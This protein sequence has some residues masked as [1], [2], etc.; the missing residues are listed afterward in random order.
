MIVGEYPMPFPTGLNMGGFY[1]QNDF[2]QF[3]NQFLNGQ[4]DMMNGGACTMM[5]CTAPGMGACNMN[6]N[7]H[8]QKCNDCEP[9]DETIRININYI[10]PLGLIRLAIIV[11]SYFKDIQ[12]HVSYL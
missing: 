10:I 9:C 4:F 1:Q 8:D 2:S 11:L 12:L 6:K 3:G 5:G 7:C